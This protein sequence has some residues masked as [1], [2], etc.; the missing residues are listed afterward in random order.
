MLNRATLNR[1]TLNRATLNGVNNEQN[2]K[3]KNLIETIK[4]KLKIK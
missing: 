3:A 2:K 1:A 4:K